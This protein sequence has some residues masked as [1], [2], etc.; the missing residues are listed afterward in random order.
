MKRILILNNDNDRQG[1][2]N[3]KKMKGIKQKVNPTCKIK[4]E[5]KLVENGKRNKEKNRKI[6]KNTLNTENTRKT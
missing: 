3:N 4:K 2:K 6:I 5:V 1:I